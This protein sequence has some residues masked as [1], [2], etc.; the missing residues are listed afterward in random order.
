MTNP[1]RRSSETGRK[2]A[3]LF[4]DYIKTDW[5]D[6][7]RAGGEVHV[8]KNDGSRYV[9]TQWAVTLLKKDV[10]A[11]DEA[12]SIWG[13]GPHDPSKSTPGW[14]RIVQDAGVEYTWEW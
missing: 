12:L 3:E 8:K 5:P 1:E 4:D 6:L 14:D 9:P 7:F 10:N 11:W 2:T 13:G